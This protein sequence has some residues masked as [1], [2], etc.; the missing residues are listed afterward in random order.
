VQ[1][2]IV[3]CV[4]VPEAVEPPQAVLN[5]IMDLPITIFINSPHCERAA[6]RSHDLQ[7]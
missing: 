3:G 7:T 1:S 5:A 6:E 2:V 4:P